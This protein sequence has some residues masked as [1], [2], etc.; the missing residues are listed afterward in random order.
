[1]KQKLLAVLV[2]SFLFL[3]YF[4]TAQ[5]VPR[6]KQNVHHA[7]WVAKNPF[8][9]KVI[10]E[11]KGQFEIPGKMAAKD[12]LFGARQGGLQY[13]FTTTGILM[14]KIILVKRSEQEIEQLEK[15]SNGK[16]KD[17]DDD[18]S[19][20]YKKVHLLHEMTFEDA[21]LQ[22]IISTDNE[23]SWYYNYTLTKNVNVQAR[24]WKKITYYNLYP[25]IDMQ[26]YFPDY[27]ET[28]LPDSLAERSF[29]YSFIVHPGADISQI[30]IK[31]NGDVKVNA[32]GT[33]TIKSDYGNFNEYVPVSKLLSS[34]KAINCDFSQS[35]GVIKFNVE[36][37]D[38]NET[39]IVDPLV[40][41]PPSYGSSNPTNA[42]YDVDQD[43]KGN[44]YAY[45]GNYPWQIL[46]YNRS[47]TLLWSYS[48]QFSGSV[49]L[50]PDLDVNLYMGDFAV[51]RNS[52][53]VYVT[54][55]VDIRNGAQVIK[56]NQKGIQI[57]EY[58][59]NSLFTEMWKI[60]FSTCSGQ[61]VI[62]GG[63]SSTPSYT[64]SYLDT[65]LTTLKLVNTLNG[66]DSGWHDMWG[67]A[68][69]DFGNSYM[70]T[71][72]SHSSINFQADSFNNIIIR[73]PLPSLAPTAW[74]VSSH[75][76]FHEINSLT[77]DLAP[78]D[79]GGKSSNGF[80]GMT[81]SDTTLYTYDSYVLK[82]WRTKNGKKIDS[83]VVNKTSEDD[84]ISWGGLAT[85]DCG[86]IFL[87]SHDTV[88]QYN[89]NLQLVETYVE[90]NTI[91]DIKLSVSDTL[92]VAGLGFISD[93]A[94]TLPPC[95]I[96]KAVNTIQD[97]TCDSSGSAT[98][99]DLSGGT[100]PYTIVWNTSPVITGGIAT[101][102]KKGTYI[103]T[104]TDSS[105]PRQVYPDTIKILG[106]IKV[107]LS[108]NNDTLC[109]G[110]PVS[111]TASGG[112]NYTWS[113]S[114]GLN[115]TTGATVIATPTV[116][117]TYTVMGT[118]S[119]GGCLDT[120]TAVINIHPLPSLTIKPPVPAICY[121]QSV[122]LTASGASSYEWKPSN[123]LSSD[124][125]STVKADPTITTTYT[126]YGSS[127]F[128]CIDSTKIVLQ[129]NPIP[130]VTI[131][132]NT[133]T[134]C[135]GKSTSLSASGATT[136]Q[137]TPSVG[138][139]QT[140]GSSVMSNPT[141]S[142]TYTAIG[143]SL[144]CSDTTSVPIRVI[145]DSLKVSPNDTSVCQGNSAVLTAT[146]ASNYVWL[147]STG[148]NQTAGSSVTATPTST[149]SYTINAIGAVGCPDTEK[150]VVNVNLPPVLTS[151]PDTQICTGQSILLSVTINVSGTSTYRWSPS[152]GL[153][154]TNGS[155]VTAN[156]TATTTYTIY[157]T[158]VF[159]C[160]DS[161]KDVVT[162]NPLPIV[163][164]L[165]LDTLICHGLS[166]T[167]TASGALTYQWSPTTAL[168]SSTNS[169]VAADPTIT[170]TY[171]VY[172]KDL[173]GCINT[174]TDTVNI[175]ANSIIISLKPTSDT[176][177]LGNSV[178]VS[179]NG[180]KNYSWS[181]SNGLTQTNDSTATANP[182]LTTTYAV[183]GNGIGG[184]ADTTNVAIIVSPPPVITVNPSEPEICNGQAI[185]LTAS[186]ASTY[187]WSPATG[188]YNT[189]GSAVDAHP[190]V[191]TNYTVIGTD[192]HGCID[193]T[194][195][196]IDVNAAPL[197]AF[198][199]SVPSICY[200]LQI[201]FSNATTD[202]VKGAITY[203]WNFGDGDSSKSPNPL[204]AFAKPGI[205]KVTLIST[206]A[207]GC[208]DTITAL[209]TLS[210]YNAGVFVAN[211]FTPTVQGVNQR[212][213]PDIECTAVTNYVFRVYDRWGMLLYE[214]SDIDATGWDGTYKGKPEPL[215]V[216]VYY[217]Q[218]NC[219]T[220]RFFK[221]GDVTLLR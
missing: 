210:N 100:P 33:I 16:E 209:D 109:L 79:E 151:I 173:L 18:D 150:I 114:A 164:L 201:Q 206:S 4:A 32:D 9:Q 53:S 74:V 10:I 2:L 47:G 187:E 112:F 166:V 94:I 34:K 42:I 125:L 167:L 121:G 57:A 142:T 54:E 135:D 6:F 65:N 126:L 117:T 165:P 75:Y 190:S 30:K 70:V 38:K 172:G 89:N 93:T 43:N 48:T 149:T 169:I 115:T 143:I 188:L 98:I 101:N 107:L 147:P 113:P 144:G 138:L 220:C 203:L 205:Y 51:D 3:V 212:F 116:N 5:N 49:F 44:I 85:D 123:S 22:T 158:D 134:I 45:G 140:S 58:L 66:P 153:N 73:T 145:Q 86:D 19:W 61:A 24:A 218:M 129:V 168:S 176:I 59:G 177:C 103:A 50:N 119:I 155:A 160:N 183:I 35:N 91:Y 108:S 8:E 148:L 211:A 40:I 64:A 88:K 216:Y 84:N 36:N 122:T 157:G 37:Y 12:I 207:N 25:G 181:P 186:G 78:F 60:A 83:L 55:G 46:K 72:H 156:P 196:T 15:K 95:H 99:T 41:T 171:T 17:D 154:Q 197:G 152:T 77:Y 170:T 56:L 82:R 92:Y 180:G 191:T 28:G 208:I 39:L 204:H 52:Q 132:P 97:V 69:D 26:F 193:S 7:K 137:W 13:Y 139:S 184:C 120:E 179:A 63:G 195:F 213:K 182:T 146:G 133:A 31:Y 202:T 87:G 111:I 131:S 71:S 161:T 80:N 200:P 68:I 130:V 118:V 136:Y 127:K 221:K 67:L 62:A 189:I 162:V 76:D 199:F 192:S 128:G 185:L 11:N 174:A 159:G 104:I 106:P 214:T 219:G 198:T 175:I 27:G 1:M 110:V 81:V 105:C 124:T 163:T 194:K 178:F 217:V 102:L 141:I 90:P 14:S 215:D 21:N 20:K 96:I 29:E 23:V